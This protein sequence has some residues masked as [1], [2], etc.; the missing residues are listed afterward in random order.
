[1]ITAQRLDVASGQIMPAHF[2]PAWAE[3]GMFFYPS[4][5]VLPERGRWRLTAQLG[6]NSGCF[7]L[8]L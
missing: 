2:S 6:R 1:M 5:T 3:N 7:D 8:T 4:G